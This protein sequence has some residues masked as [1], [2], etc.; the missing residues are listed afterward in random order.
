LSYPSLRDVLIQRQEC[1]NRDF[2]TPMVNEAK[3][4]GIPMTDIIMQI[5]E[6]DIAPGK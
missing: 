4:I 3:N 6:L 2:V 5:L 1:F